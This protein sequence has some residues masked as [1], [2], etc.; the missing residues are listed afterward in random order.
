EVRDYNAAACAAPAAAA[1]FGRQ[2]QRR[3]RYIMDEHK[4]NP[5]KCITIDGIHY[6]VIGKTRIKVTEHFQ[7]QGPSLAALLEDVITYNARSA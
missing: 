7:E 2:L 6:F 3:E 5:G 4:Q 1:A